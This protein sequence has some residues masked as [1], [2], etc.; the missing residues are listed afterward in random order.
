MSSWVWL[1]MPLSWCVQSWHT[2][3]PTMLCATSHLAMQEIRRAFKRIALEKHPDKNP[4]DPNA[5][6]VFVQI[7]TA[8]EVAAWLSY[9][10]PA[11]TLTRC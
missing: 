2:A 6:D 10:T 7:N 8:F 11:Y 1:V 9:L 4:N 5:H 3:S